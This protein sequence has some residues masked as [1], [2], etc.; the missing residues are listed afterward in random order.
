MGWT[1]SLQSLLWR[2]TQKMRA[3]WRRHQD[4]LTMPL[5]T[6]W[7]TLWGISHTFEDLAKWIL[8]ANHVWRHEGLHPEVW[9]MLEAREYQFKRCHATHQQA[10]NRTLRCLG[11]WLHGTISKVKELLIHLGGSWLCLQ[12]GWSHA[13]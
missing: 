10:L 13:M 12:V 1:V 6:I 2:P 7:R 5:T 8:L 3:S 11:Y 4:H 9:S